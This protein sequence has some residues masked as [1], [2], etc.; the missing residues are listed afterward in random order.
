MRDGITESFRRENSLAECSI[1]TAQP[2]ASVFSMSY[3]IHHP[4]VPSN[5][6][7]RFPQM[8]ILEDGVRLPLNQPSFKLKG[9]K[10]ADQVT[11]KRRDVSRVFM[12]LIICRV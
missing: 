4:E 7:V 5:L 11:R 6:Q 9:D 3:T 2:Y 10:L 1:D 12:P 8:H